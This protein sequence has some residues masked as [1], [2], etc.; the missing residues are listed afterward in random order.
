MYGPSLY[1]IPYYLT[2]NEKNQHG[3]I[4]E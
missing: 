2:T 1:R 4:V 3:F